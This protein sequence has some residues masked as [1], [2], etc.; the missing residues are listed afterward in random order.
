M[1]Q[2]PLLREGGESAFPNRQFGQFCLDRRGR[3]ERLSLIA[4]GGDKLMPRSA[5]YCF[6]AGS[7]TPS[8]PARKAAFFFM[9]QTPLLPRRGNLLADTSSLGLLVPEH[10]TSSFL[11]S[12]SGT[13]NAS[14]GQHIVTIEGVVADL[15]REGARTN[16][17]NDRSNRSLMAFSPFGLSMRVPEPAMWACVITGSEFS[18]HASPVHWCHR[19]TS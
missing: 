4:S 16:Y 13:R 10:W 15:Y 18:F 17:L 14:E 11:G 5:P 6:G 8:A 1:A 9:A 12:D 7:T 3:R 2:P 19:S